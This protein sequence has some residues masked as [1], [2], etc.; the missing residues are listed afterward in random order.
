MN[1][2]DKLYEAT[3]KPANPTTKSKYELYHDSYTKAINTALN[4]AEKNGYTTD[5]EERADIIGLKS[6]RPKDGKTERVT[7]PI[8][9]NGKKQRKHLHIQ[10]YNRGISG[11]TYEL[12]T[13][14]S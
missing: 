4:Y 13:Y 3:M 12:N 14:I 2:F 11:N 1:K 5:D 9:K 8:Y 7:L 6:S 10:V